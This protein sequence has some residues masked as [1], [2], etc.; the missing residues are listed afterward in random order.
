MAYRAP[1]HP[2]IEK[3]A[4]HQTIMARVVGLVLIWGIVG[5]MALLAERTI[6]AQHLPWKTLSVIDPVGVAT[7]AKAART[8]EDAAA[9]RAVLEQG[10][11]SF[12]EVQEVSADG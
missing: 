2:H 12:R 8:G 7:K 1:R 10:G 5:I 4:R 9:C 11:I 3:H 6:P